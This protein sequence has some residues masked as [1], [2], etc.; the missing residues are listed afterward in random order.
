MAHINALLLNKKDEN[1]YSPLGDI[2]FNMQIANKNSL[3]PSIKMIT[4][5]NVTEFENV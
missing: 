2:Q 4:L 1:I 5:Q 3:L